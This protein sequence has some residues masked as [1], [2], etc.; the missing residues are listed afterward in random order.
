VSDAAQ[1]DDE[2]FE[3]RAAVREFD[4]GYPRDEAERLA[5]DDVQR[6]E[7]QKL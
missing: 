5:R 3:E 2:F 1:T 6:W 7:E 4:G